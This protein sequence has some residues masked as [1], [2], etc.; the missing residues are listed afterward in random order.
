MKWAEV[1][2]QKKVERELRKLECT[3]HFERKK[4]G[5]DRQSREAG[6]VQHSC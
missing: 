5:P 2:R 1:S 4:R 6:W 3:V